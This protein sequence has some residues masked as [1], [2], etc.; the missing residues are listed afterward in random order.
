MLDPRV[1]CFVFPSSRR[2]CR[3]VVM[4]ALFAIVLLPA[5]MVR[6]AAVAIVLPSRSS[7]VW[8]E[9]VSRLHG[10]LLSVGAEVHMVDGAGRAQ[11]MDARA[12]FLELATQR[13]LDAII[14]IVGDEAPVTVEVWVK[15]KAPGQFE[16][17]RVDLESEGENASERS[18]I[19]ALEVLRSIFLEIDLASRARKATAPS[20]PPPA[21]PAQELNLE[22]G[23][24]TLTSPD[25]VGLAL[26]PMA[27]VGW[28]PRPWFVV[29]A[30]L[31]GFWH[32]GWMLSLASRPEGS[33]LAGLVRGVAAHLDQWQRG[34]AQV[35][36]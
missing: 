4:V 33:S 8:N 12:W 36:A 16:V 14:D 29:Q 7:P 27:R 17:S 35:G 11:S 10:E 20:S 9:T 30:A 25:G 2:V 19:R 23:A 34:G 31:A 15:G 32:A 3:S 21:R 5:A 24:A 26:L 28:A 1:P 6:A 13:G 22:V 18:A